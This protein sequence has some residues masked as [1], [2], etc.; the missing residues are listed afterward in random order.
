MKHADVCCGSESVLT[1]R[2]W[3]QSSDGTEILWL[4]LVLNL[5]PPIQTAV[6]RQSQS[7]HRDVN[8][9]KTNNLHTDSSHFNLKKERILIWLSKCLTPLNRT[10]S[11]YNWWKFLFFLIY[12]QKKLFKWSVFDPLISSLYLLWSLFWSFNWIHNRSEIKTWQHSLAS[13]INLLPAPKMIFCPTFTQHEAPRHKLS[14]A[15]SASLTFSWINMNK[16]LQSITLVS[17]LRVNV[18]IVIMIYLL[19]RW[20]VSFRANRLQI[21]TFHVSAVTFWAN[22]K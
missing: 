2:I 11:S 20:I 5:L 1:V 3:E 15:S 21:W 17:L 19:N 18:F 9:D 10:W 16:L 13:M 14:T 4:L 12:L 7:S 22:S 8:H 6:A